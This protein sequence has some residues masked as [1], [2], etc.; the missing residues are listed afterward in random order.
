MNIIKTLLSVAAVLSATSL[1]GAGSHSEL[2]RSVASYKP[3]AG[4]NHVVGDTRFVG[5]F[6]AGPDRC[7]VTLFTAGADDESLTAPARRTVLQIAAAGRSEIDAGPDSALAIA[8]NADANA[9][10][11][12]PQ[13][14]R[15]H[16]ASLN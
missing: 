13:V 1:A 16:S 5:Y 6:L 15:L 4:F 2:T 11:I 12:A 14:G 7:D 3:M 8:C 9:I 10:L